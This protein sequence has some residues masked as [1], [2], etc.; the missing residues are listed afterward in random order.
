MTT[1]EIIEKEQALEQKAI[2]ALI[3]PEELEILKKYAIITKQAKKIESDFK[4]GL[5][6][7]FK[8]QGIK[9]FENDDLKI[10]FKDTFIKRVADTDKMKKDGVYEFY[11]KETTVSPTV[12][13]TIKE[14]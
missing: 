13:L 14:Q 12:L 3:K 8:T 5:T 6:E 9:S 7:Y 10:V 1:Q 2:Q 4:K 11:T